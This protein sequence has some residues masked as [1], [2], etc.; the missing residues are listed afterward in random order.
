MKIVMFSINPIF[1]KVVTGG[2][3]KHLYHIANYLGK[4]GHQVEILCACGVESQEVF[5]WAE[6]VTVY[7]I[8]PFHLPFPQ[9]YAISG[10]ELALIADRLVEHLRSAERFY[11]HDGELLLPDLYATIPTVISFRD[12]I[13]PESVLGS[14]IGLADEILCVSE[15][16]ASVIA[17]T[18]GRF[19]PGLTERIHQVNNGIDLSVF[20]PVDSTALAQRLRV[21]PAGE[22]IVLHPHR[23]EPGKGLPETFRVADQLVHHYGVE[24]LKVLVP[25]WIGSMVSSGESK[26]YLEMMALMDT[27][28]VR[29]HFKFIPWV[30]QAEMP[31]LYSLGRGTLCLGSI[32]EAFGNV[33]YES[34]VCGTPSIVAKV[35]VHRTLL[36]EDM[37]EKVAFGDIHSAAEKAFTIIRETRR[38]PDGTIEYLRTHL[39]FEK[40]VRT[41]AEIITTVAKRPPLEFTPSQH[42]H[43]RKY[44]LAPWCYI[45]GD[46]LYHDYKNIYLPAGKLAVLAAAGIPFTRSDAQHSGVN[47][48]QWEG[49][50]EE[51]VIV[52]AFEKPK[53]E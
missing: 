2:A 28:G 38:V 48:V 5:H 51:T 15:F 41:Y 1:P 30:S 50:I 35:G 19:Y 12:N 21:D 4:Q 52:P 46:R 9:P 47:D 44:V 42:A 20:K 37:I 40:Q 24:D 53:E 10:G 11:I 13:Y 16:S 17:A 18:A 26:F 31:A 29:D 8:L 7:P 43:E 14:F 34:L 23:P 32:V 49:W 25:K 3:S 27:L 33:A 36:P 39:D 22:T 6:N 45:E